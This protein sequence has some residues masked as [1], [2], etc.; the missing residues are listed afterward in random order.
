[1]RVTRESPVRVRV[2][3]QPREAEE[4]VRTLQRRAEDSRMIQ[5]ANLLVIALG[6]TKKEKT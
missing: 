4:L 1:M 5:L 3:L 6:N 2:T